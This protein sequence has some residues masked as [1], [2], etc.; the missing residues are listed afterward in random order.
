MNASTHKRVFTPAEANQTLPLVK[1]IV[2]DIVD[3]YESVHDRQGR[4]AVI[5]QR[6][7][8]ED[9]EESNVYGEEVKQIEDE[10][11]RDIEQLE[12]YIEELRS[13]G[14]EL[15]DP[16]KGLV[17]FHTIIDGREAYL[18]WKLGEEEVLYWHELDAGFQGRQS[19]LELSE[20][21]PEE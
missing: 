20:E 13:I 2:G 5:R 11:N 17:D 15:K 3:L 4:L 12:E 14:V 7:G 8:M 18:C 19:I 6:P 16:I 21:S 9:R 1:M 10:L